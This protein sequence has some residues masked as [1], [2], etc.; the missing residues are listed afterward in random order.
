MRPREVLR[1]L[2]DCIDVAVNRGRE[3]VGEDDVLQAE[4]SYSDDA[5]VDLTLELKDIT[6]ELCDVPYGFIGTHSILSE[7]ETK[8]LLARVGV[9][10]EMLTK[11]LELLLWFGFLGL[12]IYPDEERYAYQFQHNVQMMRSGIDSFR[13][14]IHPAFRRALGTVEA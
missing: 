4:K 9:T 8:Q 13:Y 6:P 3:K 12:H 1:F 5:L 14:C 2:R 7:S 10:E 11:V